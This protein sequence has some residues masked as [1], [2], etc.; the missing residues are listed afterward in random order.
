MG[1][2]QGHRRSHHPLNLEPVPN[3][4]A[5]ND[6][7]TGIFPMQED[8]TVV[9][10]LKNGVYYLSASGFRK[11]NSP[12]LASIA[13]LR[14]YA[15]IPINAQWM[16]LA[17]NNG[18]VHI[19]NTA[20]EHI[21]QF[22]KTEGLQNNNILSIFLDRQQNLWLGLDNG[23][24]FIAY[25]SA[26]KRIIPAGQD[27]SGY[28]TAIY[29]QRLYAGTS[30]GLFSVPLQP[31]PDLSF[32]KGVFTPV[33]N[34]TGQVW[35]LAE[36]NGQ[37]LMG[38]HD[39]AYAIRDETAQ[40]LFPYYAGYWNFVP[41]QDVFPA[42]HIIAGNYRGLSL[43]N[44]ENGQF[45]SMQQLPG[46]QESSRFVALDK[47]GTIW[48]SHPYHGVYRVQPGANGVYSY[49]LY[50]QKKGLPSSLNNHVYKVKGEILV[51]TEKG[52]YAYEA[53]SDRFQ[54]VAFYRQ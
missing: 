30:G 32:S 16:A 10:T 29:R 51:A 54:P 41:M 38:H 11:L 25:N 6:A 18:G 33:A 20:G 28:T 9:A 3:A 48:V 15:A 43:I 24:D 39:G 40:P 45:Q 17:T 4:L 2:E 13:N 37:L 7:V 23:I 1:A 50:D 49:Q 42:S 34:T 47:Q 52:V 53:A 12:D 8:S 26:I 46:F 21:Q 36:I 27:G 44:Y 5:T 14:I 31:M 22:T 35:G 19:V